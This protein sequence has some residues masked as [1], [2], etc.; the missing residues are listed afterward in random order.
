MLRFYLEMAEDKVADL[1]GV[2]RGTVK[3]ATSRGVA[4]VGRM[5]REREGS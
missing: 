2:S 1:M 4:A 5:L 3:S